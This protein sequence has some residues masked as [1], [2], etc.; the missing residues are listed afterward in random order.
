[1]A[2]E[3]RIKAL[4]EAEKEQ[5]E[6]ASKL[7]ESEQAFA[8]MRAKM[9]KEREMFEVRFRVLIEQFEIFAEF[10]FFP[11]INT[12]HVEAQRQIRYAQERSTPGALTDRPSDWPEPIKRT[13]PPRKLYWKY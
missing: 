9:A 5:I 1:M 4:A 12:Y 7:K 11:Q 10:S 13:F 3:E 8:E 2:D 6:A